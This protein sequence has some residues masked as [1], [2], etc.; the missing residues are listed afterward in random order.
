MIKP[1]PN[2]STKVRKKL[3]REDSS[4]PQKLKKER[5]ASKRICAT[6]GGAEVKVC[7]Y[8]PKA[9]VTVAAEARPVPSTK[10]PAKSPGN[11]PGNPLRRKAAAPA[12]TG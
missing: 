10:T 1:K 11:F 12:L 3:T 5:L 8:S 4:I 7:K 2:T 6:S 9:T